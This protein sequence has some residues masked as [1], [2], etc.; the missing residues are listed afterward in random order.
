M[1]NPFVS[2][3]LSGHTI[4]TLQVHGVVPVI[5]SYT[6]KEPKTPKERR[7]MR[8]EALVSFA[9]LCTIVFILLSTDN[10]LLFAGAAV[11]NFLLMTYWKNLAHVFFDFQ[12]TRLRLRLL[13]LILTVAILGLFV[14]GQLTLFNAGVIMAMNA[15]PT[16]WALWIALRH[17]DIVIQRREA[18]R[19]FLAL[20]NS[21]IK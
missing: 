16:F 1:K 21:A 20:N 8:A 3:G 5:A 11:V 2:H 15:I 17:P 14:I 7:A 13:P 4:Q 10:F 6:P 19:K 12:L 9:V 18:I